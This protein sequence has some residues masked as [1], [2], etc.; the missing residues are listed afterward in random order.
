MVSLGTGASGLLPLGAAAAS[1]EVGSMDFAVNS[2]VPSDV[3]TRTAC[4]TKGPP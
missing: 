2:S 1:T 3:G 4:D